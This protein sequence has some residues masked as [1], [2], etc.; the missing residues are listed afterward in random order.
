M[1]PNVIDF[2][3]AAGESTVLQVIEHA[4]RLG[5]A[6]D[7]MKGWNDQVGIDAA[8]DSWSWLDNSNGFVSNVNAINKKYNAAATQDSHEEIISQM[9]DSITLGA[10][11]RCK[12]ISEDVVDISEYISVPSVNSNSVSEEHMNI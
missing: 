7:E 1:S 10:L 3:S 8:L 2:T 9:L 12:H 11:Y 6:L 5:L 4:E